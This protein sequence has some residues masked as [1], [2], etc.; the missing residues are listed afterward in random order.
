MRRKRGYFVLPNILTAGSLFCGFFSMVRSI[1]GDFYIASI[2]ILIAGILDGIDGKVARITRTVSR[3]GVEFD[4]LS[5]LVSFGVAPS[6]LTYLH[7]FEPFSRVGIAVP[8]LYLSSGALR[9]ARF[10]IISKRMDDRYF[11]GLPIPA[12]ASALVM[13]III[14]ERFPSIPLVN[15]YFYFFL[16]FT[17][18]LLMVSN[19]RYYSF[20]K[21]GFLKGSPWRVLITI[22]IAFT[23]L[24]SEPE[25][26]L[27]LC[28]YAYVLSGPLSYVYYK[29][30]VKR[31]KGVLHEAK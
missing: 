21:A 18:S 7:F 16:S 12:A 3:F 4:S 19:I 17:L 28:I 14:S 22:V 5:D 9:L 23:I 6:V 27:F 31:A 10:N 11:L 24:L 13:P 8:F 2:L 29:V 15:P 20:K 25:V 26:F 1:T 30:K